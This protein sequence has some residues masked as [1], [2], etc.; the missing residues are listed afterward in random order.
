MKKFQEFKESLTFILSINSIGKQLVFCVK[1][2][3][4]GQYGEW[5]DCSASC[6]GGNRN[7]NRTCLGGDGNGCKGRSTETEV[8]LIT[9]IVG[10]LYNAVR[11]NLNSQRVV[12]RFLRA[13]CNLCRRSG[14]PV[15]WLM[16]N[17]VPG[18]R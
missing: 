6:G 10:C 14:M 4:W 8:S 1:L 9:E 13:A 2:L 7:R 18:I 16:H 15:C 3:D 17:F 5:S 12:A 11:V